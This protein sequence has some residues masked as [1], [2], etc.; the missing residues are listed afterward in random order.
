[1]LQLLLQYNILIAMYMTKPILLLLVL[2]DVPYIFNL[3]LAN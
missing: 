2:V 1:M 3:Y